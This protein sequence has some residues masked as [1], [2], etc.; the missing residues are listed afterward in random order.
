[1]TA[2]RDWT[3]HVTGIGLGALLILIVALVG[4]IV[5]RSQSPRDAAQPLEAGE[6]LDPL[7][8]TSL[9]GDA[10]RLDYSDPEVETVL[11]IFSTACPACRGNMDNWKALVAGPARVGRR[12]YYVSGSTAGSTQAFARRFA[13][14]G[15]VL[16]GG[17]VELGR[18]RLDRIPATVAIAPGGRV[19][20]VWL[21]EV[22]QEAFAPS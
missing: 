17:A 12:F 16:L 11:L 19:R 2:P 9:T 8:L 13:L 3:R 14:T 20:G 4:L 6:F 1:M 7:E 21:G 18:L 5:L 22:P 15:L 10:A